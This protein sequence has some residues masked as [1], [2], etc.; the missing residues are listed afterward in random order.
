[1]LSHCH[2]VVR[3]P[4]TPS[5]VGLVRFGST[6]WLELRQSYGMPHKKNAEV[7][8]VPVAELFK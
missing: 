7:E 2:N 3:A 6:V 1:M 4:K 8:V 5:S